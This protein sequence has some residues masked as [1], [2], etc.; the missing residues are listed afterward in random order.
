MLCEHSCNK[1][2]R[3]LDVLVTCKQLFCLIFD[4]YLHEDKLFMGD[5]SRQDHPYSWYC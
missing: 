5:L 1:T 2:A 3:E 4:L